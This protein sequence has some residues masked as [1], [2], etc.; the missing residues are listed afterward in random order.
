MRAPSAVVQ[1]RIC[2][3]GA[4]CYL[5]DQAELGHDRA[6]RRVL[7]IQVA[8]KLTA[9]QVLADVAFLEILPPL[10]RVDHLREGVVP[11]RD[12]G[13]RQLLRPQESAPRGYARG[14]DTLL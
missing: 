14:I 8:A 4:M 10:G 1:K 13:R 7:G 11:E 3:R 2:W 5:L 6:Y 12:L 9:P